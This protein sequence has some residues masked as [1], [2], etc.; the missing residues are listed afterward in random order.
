MEPSL[1]TAHSSA[2]WLVACGDRPS[3]HAIGLDHEVTMAPE[4]VTVNQ[5][6]KDPRIPFTSRK[7]LYQTIERARPKRDSKGNVVDPGDPEFLSA[8]IR[9]SGR[10]RGPIF[11]DVDRLSEVLDKRRLGGAA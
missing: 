1:Q 11:I 8:F 6:L 4:L 5:A 10:S 9:P 7:G 2:T 3:P